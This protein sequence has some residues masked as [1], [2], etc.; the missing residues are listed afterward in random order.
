M[1]IYLHKSQMETPVGP[2]T[3]I[4]SESGLCALEFD[5][6]ERNILLSGR[7]KH[8]DSDAAL[9]DDTNIVID[10]VREWLANYFAG[11]F[12]KLGEISL[13]HRGT[14]FELAV[15]NAM[16]KI[17]VGSVATYSSLAEKIGRPKAVRAVGNASRRN[18]IALIIPCHR[19]IGKSGSLTGYGGGL[20]KKRW[21]LQHEVKAIRNNGGDEP[22][23]VK[24]ETRV[25]KM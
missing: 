23:G 16:R 2:M 4:A 17:H 10:Q 18:P 3:A 9:V 13:D 21:L 22:Y 15:W 25:R 12:S 19:V 7:L 6:P 14:D 20:D 24:H 1:L 8:W 11:E 5:R